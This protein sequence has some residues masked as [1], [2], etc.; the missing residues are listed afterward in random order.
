MN[1]SG[2]QF[3]YKE[4]R[5]DVRHSCSQ[6]TEIFVEGRGYFGCIKNESRGGVFIETKGPFIPGQ[7]ILLKYLTP[8]GLGQEKTGTIVKADTEG[9]GVRYKWPGYNL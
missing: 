8:A 3:P 1:I 7:S 4:K 5:R 6:I 2:A 9:I